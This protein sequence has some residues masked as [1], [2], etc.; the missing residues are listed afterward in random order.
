MLAVPPPR[1][2]IVSTPSQRV[3]V[4]LRRRLALRELVEACIAQRP[5][6]HAP[7]ADGAHTGRTVTTKSIGLDRHKRESQLAMKTCDGSITDRE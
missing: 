7:P 2:E 4:G 1:A 3:I 5:S 6:T